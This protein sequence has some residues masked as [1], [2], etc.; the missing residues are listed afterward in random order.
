MWEVVCGDCIEFLKKRPSE[1]VDAIVT[2][3]PYALKFMGSEW[4]TFDAQT[5]LAWCKAWSAELLRVAKP[6]A[7]LLAFGGTRTHH[8]LAC[9]IEDAGWEIRDDILS[10]MALDEKFSALWESLNEDQR[11]ALVEVLNCYGLN[12]ILSWVYATGFPKSL[13]VSKAI[14]DAL[15]NER[16]VI[17]P[18]TGPASEEAAKW[19]GWGTTL[20]PAWE[21]IILARK[22]LDGTVARTVLTHGTGG[23]NVEGCRIQTVENLN[24]GAYAK[25]GKRKDLPGAARSDAAAGMMAPGKTAGR[26]FQQP[27]GR[28]PANL[29]LSHSSDCR[30]L[31]IEKEKRVYVST[32]TGKTLEDEMSFE[33]W[34]CAP[35]CPIRIMNEQSGYT[36]T[37]RIEKPS[38]C[39][40]NTWGGTIQIRRGARG[41]TDAGGASRFFFRTKAGN[42][43]RWFYCEKCKR[44]FPSHLREE[45][46]HEQ[47]RPDHIIV[48]PTQ[49]PLGVMRWLVR[50]VSP[51]GGVVLDPFCGSG[52]TGCAALKEGIRFIGVEKDPSYVE[53]AK[54]RLQAEE[55]QEEQP[56]GET[57][58]LFSVLTI[59]P[60]TGQEK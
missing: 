17:G 25:K 18:K 23:I 10:L 33:K 50:L 22:P 14:D 32:E 43:E 28:W 13:D 12:G 8:R 41:Y 51:V 42:N 35:E 45:H 29:L 7:H 37:K 24:G 1:S 47:K 30:F 34:E 59:V 3:P 6:G 27:S 57:L 56:K 55:L 31:G 20:K 5:F 38:D 21:P 4:D 44:A 16:P 39:G 49:K 60:V 11:Q 2:D 9:A 54:A 58:S 53:I 48:H 19:A 15:G 46:A 40:G 52:T 26:E 36:E